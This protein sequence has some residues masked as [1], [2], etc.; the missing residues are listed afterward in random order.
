MRRSAL[1][2]LLLATDR[3]VGTSG[4]HTR[5]GHARS[6]YPSA[7]LDPIPWAVPVFAVVVPA[8]TPTCERAVYLSTMGL[9]STRTLER[10]LLA[11]DVDAF[12]EFVAALWGESGWTVERDGLV[13]DV[14]H[15]GASKRLLVLPPRR[16]A[17]SLRRAPSTTSPIDV[18]VAPLSVTDGSELPR[19]TPDAEIVDAAGLRERLCYA[20]DDGTRE[21]LLASY[22]GL[23]LDDDSPSAGFGPLPVIRAPTP[24]RATAASAGTILLL[25]G[26][27]LLVVATGVPSGGSTSSGMVD[28]TESTTAGSYAT[29]AAPVYDAQKTCERGPGEV[30]QL[31]TDAVRGS[32][33]SRGLVVMGDFW[34]PRLV[35]AMPTGAWFER[36]QSD[37]RQ[38]FYGASEVALAAP[39]IDGDEAVVNATATVDGSQRQYAFVLSQTSDGSRQSC[40]VIDQFGP[41]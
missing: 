33:L 6:D 7:E 11:L 17:P 2:G 1:K 16:I 15:Q 28:A 9:L 5:V 34:N 30:A 39:S 27:L 35:Q 4:P 19:Q 26:V 21:R 37:D 25:T 8:P 41:A 38:S 18:V 10:Q 3:V 32:S 13:L 22:L 31:S 23:R 36:M 12:V 14:S 29:A 40:W 24:G 20:V